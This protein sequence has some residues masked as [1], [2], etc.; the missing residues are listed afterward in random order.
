MSGNQALTAG[1]GIAVNNFSGG[2][3]T[4]SSF[5]TRSWPATPRP[6]S[7]TASIRLRATSGRR[8]TTSSETPPGC[9]ASPQTGDQFGTGASPVDPR[10][11][12]LENNGGPTFTMA[13]LPGSPAIGAADPTTCGPTDQRGFVIAHDGDGH[14]CDIGA[15]EVFL[16]PKLKAAPTISGT[17][18]LGS[19]LTCSTGKWGGATPLALLVPGGCATA[20]RSTAPRPATARSPRR[21]WVRS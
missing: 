6:T 5:T 14:G 8:G 17:R 21:I 18:N 13:L 7:P 9:G 4:T 1:G 3:P 12:H 15:Y 20:T 2:C 10:L 16:P 19:Q 11:G